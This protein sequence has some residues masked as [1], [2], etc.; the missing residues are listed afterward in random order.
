MEYNVYCDESCH[1]EHDH[2]NKMVVGCVWLP[3]CR[4]REIAHELKTI[5]LRYNFPWEVY[6]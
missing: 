3:R 5:N 1:L 6:L 4:V 2:I